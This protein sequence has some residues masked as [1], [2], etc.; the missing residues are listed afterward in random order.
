M[1]AECQLK[2]TFFFEIFIFVFLA[3]GAEAF[4]TELLACSLDRLD[5]ST[6]K[7]S[8]S[9]DFYS[10]NVSLQSFLEQS[11]ADLIL[12]FWTE[13]FGLFW[14]QKAFKFSLLNRNLLEF[15]RSNE[16]C[17]WV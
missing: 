9:S 3:D 5:P 4:D 14:I 12:F 10:L 11:D 15:W 16:I 2:K 17:V 7:P 8:K 1:K 6:W 13:S